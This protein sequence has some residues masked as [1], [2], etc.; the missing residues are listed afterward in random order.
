[1]KTMVVAQKD[2]RLIAMTFALQ[3]SRGTRQ[4]QQGQ[5]FHY[6]VS[7]SLSNS[8]SLPGTAV[9]LLVHTS[10][11]GFKSHMQFALN[12]CKDH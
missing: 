1:M 5:E 12:G 6:Y 2:N 4:Y 11:R 10:V 7:I 3:S 8:N 9:V